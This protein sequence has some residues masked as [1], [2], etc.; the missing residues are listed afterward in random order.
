MNLRKSLET[1]MQKD[2]SIEST[3]DLYG[4]CLSGAMKKTYEKLCGRLPDKYKEKDSNCLSYINHAYIYRCCNNK[5]PKKRFVEK[6]RA[7]LFSEA[8]KVVDEYMGDEAEEEDVPEAPLCNLYS[9]N[10]CRKNY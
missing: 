2:S 7:R 9:F 10:D 1:R 4:V 8:L 3:A 5:I 6:C